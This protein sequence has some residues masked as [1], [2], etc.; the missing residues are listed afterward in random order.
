M[1]AN[2]EIKAPLKDRAAT[3]ATATR[4]ADSGPETPY[5]EDIFFRCEGERLKLRSFNSGQPHSHGELIRYQRD[6]V[7][8]AHCSRYSIAR[9]SDS[10][11]LLDILAE[12]LGIVGTVNKT[13]ILY[14]VG[15]AR[16][17]I[18]Q[19]EGFGDFLEL[20]VVLRQDQT[21]EESKDIRNEL[22]R[23]FRIGSQDRIAGAYSNPRIGGDRRT[24]R[25]S[26]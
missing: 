22:L 17:H 2:L 23:K 1:P 16:I 19:V 15:Q 5:Q 25:R 18:D 26:A 20:Q 6:N 24:S 21:Q 13:R 12:T 8:K 14:L 9:T 10:R 3:I 4:V 11:I 7:A